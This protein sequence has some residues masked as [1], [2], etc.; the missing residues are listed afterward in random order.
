MKDGSRLP[1]E[2]SADMSRIGMMGAYDVVVYT[3]DVCQVPHLHVIDKATRGQEFDSR[4]SLN[5]ASYVLQDGHSDKLVASICARFNQFMREP[6]RNVHYRNNYEAAVN[7]W[8]DNNGNSHISLCETEENEV[9]IPD[10]SSL[11]GQ[12]FLIVSSIP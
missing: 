6:S 2:E 4:I 3:D 8:N 7:L 10:Y 5:R 11:N 9:I 12:D 1:L